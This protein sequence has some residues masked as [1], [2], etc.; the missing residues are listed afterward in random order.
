MHKMGIDNCLKYDK[1][2]KYC[3]IVCQNQ[4]NVAKFVRDAIEILK[5]KCEQP[6]ISN[7]S[8]VKTDSNLE[9]QQTR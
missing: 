8:N 2:V 4:K 7:D 5:K 9:V 1:Y 6:K 3:Q